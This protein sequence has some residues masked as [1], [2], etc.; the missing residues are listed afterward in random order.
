MEEQ[1]AGESEERETRGG[2]WRDKTREEARS[3][4]SDML[5]M[6]TAVLYLTSDRWPM[7]LV[8]RRMAGQTLRL[9]RPSGC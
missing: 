7:S 8:M 9:W 4:V 5:K 3:Y 6:I 1:R 2:V